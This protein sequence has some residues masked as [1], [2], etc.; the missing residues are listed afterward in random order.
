MLEILRLNLLFPEH[1]YL[2]ENH[3]ARRIN[4]QAFKTLS[5]SEQVHYLGYQVFEF[6]IKVLARSR[7][8][9]SL[10]GILGIRKFWVVLKTTKRFYKR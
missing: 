9:L 1:A 4:H 2:Q 7:L 8:W 3:F 10:R 6:A 5:I